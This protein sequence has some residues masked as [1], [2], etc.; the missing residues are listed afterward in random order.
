MK[1]RG[2]R[3]VHYNNNNKI[4]NGSWGMSSHIVGFGSVHYNNNNIKI[5]NG[6]SMNEE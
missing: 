1:K 3:Y 2:R 5:D 4:Y 6:G